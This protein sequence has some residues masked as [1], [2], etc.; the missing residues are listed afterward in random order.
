[1]RSSAWLTI[2][3]ASFIAAVPVCVAQ[4]YA[5]DLP[6]TY[7]ERNLKDIA[8]NIQSGEVVSVVRDSLLDSMKR[9]L[10]DET[11]QRFSTYEQPMIP[12]ATLEDSG[13]FLTFSVQT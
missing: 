10:N 2:V 9:L 6:V 13:I 1:M 12:L 11:L 4:Q 5:I 8:V 3:S 7:N